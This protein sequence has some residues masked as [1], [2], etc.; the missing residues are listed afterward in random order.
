MTTTAHLLVLASI[1]TTA[2][3]ATLTLIVLGG[4]GIAYCKGVRA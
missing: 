4:Y 3:W 1:A 2:A